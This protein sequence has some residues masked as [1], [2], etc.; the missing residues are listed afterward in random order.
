MVKKECFIYSWT[1]DQRCEAFTI[2]RAY[3]IDE[4]NKNVCLSIK[5]FTPYVYIELPTTTIWTQ[6]AVAALQDKM[7]EYLKEDKPVLYKLVYKRKLFYAH[8]NEKNEIKTFPFLLCAF[9]HDNIIKKRLNFLNYGVYILGSKM[10]F[11]VHEN[12]ASPVLQ[13]TSL[14]RISTACWVS[15]DGKEMTENDKET[16]ADFEYEVKWK[17]LTKVETTKV[18]RPLLMGYDIEV[19]SSNPNAFPNAEK[20]ADKIFQISCVLA[21]QGDNPCLWK[22]YLLTLGKADS[23]SLENIILQEYDK[24]FELLNAFVALIKQHQPNIIIGYNI[25]TFDIPYTIHRAKHNL[26][27]DTFCK[28]GIH[29]Y[30]LATEK[31][32]KWSSSAYGQQ[33]FQFL[34]AEGRLFVDLLPL[35][36]R[37]YKLNSY[38]L[39]TI[40]THFLKDMT[41][42][43]L[44]EKGIFYCYREGMKG[45]ERGRKALSLVGK[46]CVKDSELVVRLFETLTTWVALCEMSNIT[47]VPIFSLFTQGQQLKVFS[48]VYRKCSNENTVVERNGYLSS[49]SERYV[50]A[51]VF[52]PIPGIYEKVV[53]F[54]FNSLYPTSIIAKNIDYSTLV[55]DDKI[56]DDLCHVMEWEEHFGC[57]HDIKIKR[58]RELDVIIAKV[59]SSI[60]ELRAE[61]D[62]YK[63]KNKVS[64]EKR[65]TIVAKIETVMSKLKPY[66]EERSALIKTIPKHIT[67]SKRKY[68]WLKE[69]VGVLPDILKNLLSSRADTKK[70][71]KAVKLKLNELKLNESKLITDQNNLELKTYYD[72]LDQRQNALKISANS[73]YGSMGVDK[74]YLPFMPGAMCTTYV[75]RTAI[76]KAATLIKNDFKGELVYGDTDSNYISFPQFETAEQCWDYAIEVAKKVS[77][78]FPRP[79]ALA[80][81]EKIYWKFLILTKKRYVSLA[82]ERDG[83]LNEKILKKGVLL[84]RRDSSDFVKD[85]YETVIMMIFNKKPFSEILFY[86]VEQLNILCSKSFSYKKFIITKAVGDTNNYADEK[87]RFIPKSSV[88]ELTGKTVY[89]IGDYKVPILKDSDREHKMNLKKAETETEYY[90]RCLP[91]QMQLALKM[92]D[93]GRPVSVGTRLEYVI[94]TQGGDNAKQYEKI[95]SVDYYCKHSRVLEIDY[96]YYLKQL[97]N[98]LDQVIDILYKGKQTDIGQFKGNFVLE[99]YKFRT[100]VREPVLRSIRNTTKL[101]FS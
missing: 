46:Y 55:M 100:K 7:D 94:T 16:Y 24:E 25:F 73:V 33:V 32:I 59:D 18:A 96:L 4:N 52:P 64:Q 51:T 20:D 5:D 42:D 13:L 38:K 61:R 85:T 19:N 99:Q 37:D 57:T 49:E 58:K 31:T 9:N 77:A 15:F 1:V 101:I 45:G 72:V 65:A 69:P 53:P 36:K 26:V 27:F 41:K 70:E 30:N 84:N 80:F 79:M 63:G 91:A 3:G 39:K 74:G 12:N 78:C 87:T 50:G 89:K 56:S 66:K 2:I 76:E 28:Q 82:C 44:D 75:G 83:K 29:K 88:D 98:P 47:N 22:K 48:Q 10:H 34:D 81:E 35:V 40:A 14:R 43:P 11:K 54:D 95:E 90:K 21:R 17:T 86:I 8:L 92:E 60:K 6:G 23:A 97:S 71:M 93:R 62:K 68:R 67:C